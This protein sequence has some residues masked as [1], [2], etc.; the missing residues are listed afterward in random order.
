MRINI[1]LRKKTGTHFYDILT[2]TW[3]HV[4]LTEPLI[5]RYSPRELRRSRF[6]RRRTLQRHWRADCKLS[7]RCVL[8]LRIRRLCITHIHLILVILRIFSLHYLHYYHFPCDLIEDARLSYNTPRFLMISSLPATCRQHERVDG[9]SEVAASRPIERQRER[10]RER[11]NLISHITCAFLQDLHGLSDFQ[12]QSIAR[13]P[14]P[15]VHSCKREHTLCRLPY[16]WAAARRYTR[17]GIPGG[18]FN[19]QPPPSF[20]G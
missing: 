3:Q 17:D 9:R 7:T 18:I 5:F 10:E 2:T 15:V 1:N 11:E 13:V 19:E 4:T 14:P 20:I 6:G 12:G 16:P 8:S